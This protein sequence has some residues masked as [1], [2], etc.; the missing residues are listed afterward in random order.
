M[1]KIRICCVVGCGNPLVSK[2]YCGRH[3][4]QIRKRGH[5][6]NGKAANGDLQ[7]FVENV[8]LQF[9]SDECLPWPYGKNG[10]GYGSMTFNRKFGDAHVFVCRLAHGEPPSPV[11]EVAHNCGRRECCNP[12]HLRWATRRENHADKIKHK[13]TNS[14]VR[15]GNCKLSDEQV[16]EIRALKGVLTYAEIANRFGIN[17]D[18]VGHLIRR[19]SRKCL[20]STAV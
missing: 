20:E 7:A 4:Q 13:T 8:A 11:H 14:S 19:Q 1:A 10:A 3:Y 9:D 17:K 2:G 12:R 16:G 15:N 5:V 6:H 18:Y